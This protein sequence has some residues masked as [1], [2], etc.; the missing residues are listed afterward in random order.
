MVVSNQ[1]KKDIY[2][3]HERRRLPDNLRIQPDCRHYVH[4]ASGGR[5][6]WVAPIPNDD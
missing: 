2:Y 6:Y 3:E 1:S 5:F 4:M